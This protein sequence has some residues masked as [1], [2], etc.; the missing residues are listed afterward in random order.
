MIKN[1]IDV[2]NYDKIIR[3]KEKKMCRSTRKRSI[4]NSPTY[5]NIKSQCRLK[6]ETHILLTGTNLSADE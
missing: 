3:K 5:L 4:N 6:V 1:S 2:Y